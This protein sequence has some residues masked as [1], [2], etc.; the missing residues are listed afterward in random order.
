MK[1]IT[2]AKIIYAGTIVTNKYLAFDETIIGFTDTIS[3][4]A[5]VY[6]AKGCYVSAGFCDTHTHGYAGYD[7][8]YDGMEAQRVASKLLPQT[9]VTS[10][11]PTMMTESI[12]LMR[13]GADFAREMTKARGGARVLGV[14]FEGP[15][16]NVSK[17]GAQAEEAIIPA[18]ANLLKGV[19][20]VVKIIT[21]A[22]ETEGAIDQIALLR[23]MGIK[24][25]IGHSNATYQDC[26]KA[27]DAGADRVTHLFNAQSPLNHR[28]P[29]IVGTALIDDRVYAEI[30]ADTCHITGDLLPM[31][32]KVLNDRFVLITDSLAP[33]NIIEGR[34]SNFTFDGKVFRLPDGVIAGSALT[35]DRGVYNLVKVAKMSIVNAVKC[36][37]EIPLTSIGVD[38]RGTLDI[39]NWA[40]IVVFD[41]DIDIKATFVEGELVYEK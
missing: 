40:D 11:L 31:L 7:Y 4:G 36:A 21:V 14:N 9:G 32:A 20:D 39:G 2:N 17:K 27:L 30:I 10:F 35:M 24:V 33:T 22:P 25:S 29:G 34:T 41:E 26:L 1:I 12:P 5:T 23:D 18:D 37:S 38:D 13:Q 3:E 16:I 8:T 6:D 15:F 19:E 28:E